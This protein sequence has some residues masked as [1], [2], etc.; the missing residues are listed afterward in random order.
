[1][2]F[3]GGPTKFVEK[4][5]YIHRNPV[6]R[7]LV[8]KPEDWVR[9]SFRHYACGEVGP[10]EIKSQWAARKRERVGIFLTLRMRTSAKDP[11]QA[12]LGRGTRR[13]RDL[14]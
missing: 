2:T 11:T 4:L 13:G 14:G 6:K 1:M 8:E 5:R 9:T 12:E 7:S 3:A 10:V